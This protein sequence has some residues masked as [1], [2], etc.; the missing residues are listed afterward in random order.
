M[1]TLNIQ[2]DVPDMGTYEVAELKRM[3]TEYAYKI[4]STTK[5]DTTVKEKKYHHEALAGIFADINSED[6]RDEYIKEKYGI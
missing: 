4:V 2:I 6:M 3:L 5:T 1:A